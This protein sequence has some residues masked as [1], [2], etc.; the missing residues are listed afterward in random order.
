MI[1]FS[2]S[3]MTHADSLST[4]IIKLY[5]NGIVVGTC[6]AIGS[7]R[8]EGRDPDVS[9]VWII[10]DSGLRRNDDDGLA[11]ILPFGSKDFADDSPARKRTSV[12]PVS[13]CTEQ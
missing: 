3:F 13:Q 12:Q 4:E 9:H 5:S 2:I 6:E 1:I 8:M 10:V 11:P 7:G